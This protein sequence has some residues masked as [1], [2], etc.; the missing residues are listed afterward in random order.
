MSKSKHILFLPG[1]GIGPE[2]SN[3]ANKVLLY[4]SEKYDFDVEVTD[5]LI[6][7]IAIDVEGSPISDSTIEIAKDS[8][9][10]FLGG[11][12]GPKWDS[13]EPA[14]KPEKGL[15]KIRS[16]LDLFA[17]LRPSMA[18]PGLEDTSSLKKEVIEGLNLSLIHI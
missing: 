16:E 7:G 6:G 11:V 17:N 1:D 10:I 15:L 18:F 12:G 3:E 5:R 2:I 4:V 13:L 8:D 14:K 9:A